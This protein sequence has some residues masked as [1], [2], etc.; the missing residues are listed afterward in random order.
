MSRKNLDI[1][2]M[3]PG[4]VKVLKAKE[5]ENCR[6]TRYTITWRRWVEGCDKFG[7]EE[8]NGFITEIAEF[9]L[10]KNISDARIIFDNKKFYLRR[11][12]VNKDG[13]TTIVDD[14]VIVEPCTFFAPRSFEKNHRS[15]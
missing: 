15:I 6:N 4:F 1:R 8:C 14:P 11:T 5:E 13:K 12:W 3:L 2:E 7:S 9:V 10:P